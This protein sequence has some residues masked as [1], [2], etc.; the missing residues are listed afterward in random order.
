MLK[1]RQMSRLFIAASKDQMEPIIQELYRHNVFHIEDFVDQAREEYAGFRIGMPLSGASEVSSEL[2]KIRSLAAAYMVKPDDEEP[3]TIRRTSDIRSQIERDLPI[4]E[5]E[6][7]GLTVMRSRLENEEKD[8]E[9]K[10]LG[11]KHFEHIPVDLDLLQGYESIVVFAGSIAH[12]VAP[13]VPH[14]RFYYPSKEGN[15]IVIAVPVE[16]Q[17]T[18]EKALNEAM[19]Q[20]VPIPE[21]TGPASDAIR[22]YQ[23][24]AISIKEQIEANKQKL[25]DNRKKYAGFLLA[26]D[27]LLTTDVSKAEAPLRFATTDQAFVAEGWVPVHEVE[28]LTRAVN[29][30]TGGKCYITE[31]PIDFEHDSVPVEYDNPSFVKPTQLIIDIYARPRYSEIDPTLIVAF[32]FPLFFGLILGD[33]GYGLLLLVVS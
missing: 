6:T 26:C 4:I 17:V 25:A 8:L 20:Q 32:I 24:Q 19:F 15:F 7:D 3:E 33:V 27:E 31:I 23:L 13:D 5:K 28:P 14:D 11:L 30:V 12:D 1:P 10:I 16:H 9:Q 22:S 18:V 29:E 2:I 21:E